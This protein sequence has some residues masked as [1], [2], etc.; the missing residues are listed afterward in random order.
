MA[1]IFPLLSSLPITNPVLIF[2]I[3]MLV[4]FLVPILSV[5]LRIP[6]IVGLIVTGIILGPNC[7]NVF[8]RDS[9]DSMIVVWGTVG[10]LYIMLIAGLEFDL[11]QFSRRKHRSIVFGLLEFVITMAATTYLSTLLL[12][13][14]LLS[15]ILL[16][17]M[18]A[19]R[20]LVAYPII[21]RLGLVKRDSI[22][23]TLGGTV[24]TDTATLLVLAVVA[25]VAREGLSVWFCCRL[26]ISLA[27]FFLI[28]FWGIPRLG[29][30]FFRNIGG[31]GGAQFLFVLTVVF[32]CGYLSY[33]AGI[34]PIIGAF[35]SG[36]AL[37]R[38]IPEDSLL[39]NRILFVG[40]N[41]FV[42]VFLFSIGM[43]VKVQNLLSDVQIWVV[44]GVM[45]ASA[46][47]TKYLA[48]RIVQWL[49]KYSTEESWVIFGL[50]I[51]QAAAALAIAE[52]GYEVGLFNEAVL[53]GTVILIIVTCLMSPWVVERFGRRIALEEEAPPHHAV[54]MN[55]RLLVPVSNP[56]TAD[57]I[58]DFALLF[59]DPLRTKAVYP[60]TVVPDDG[61]VCSH[62]ANG[63]KLVSSCLDRAVEASVTPVV[64]ADM[65]AVDGIT[66]AVKDLR[67]TTLIMGWGGEV[68]AGSLIFGNVLNQVL[69]RCDQR[70]I[71]CRLTHP[72]NTAK[73]LFLAL[74]PF[75]E[76]ESGFEETVGHFKRFAK[77]IG[78]NFSVILLEHNLSK[79][80]VH[81]ERAK[82]HIPA[83]FIS[84]PSW[85][86]VRRFI[87]SSLTQDDVVVILSARED[88]VSWQPGLDR[89]PEIV[90]ARLPQTNLVIVYPPIEPSDAAVASAPE[91]IS[92]SQTISAEE[93][94][95]LNLDVL[96]PEQAIEDIL[97]K[98]FADRPDD[99]G[100]LLAQIRETTGE[101]PTELL[102][103]V[104]LLHTHC[105]QVETTKVFFGVGR[106]GVNFAGAKHPAHIVFVVLSSLTQPP[107]VHL[108]TLVAIGRLFRTPGL[109]ERLSSAQSAQE[110]LDV[111]A[112]AEA[113][114]S[115]G[116]KKETAP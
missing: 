47:A 60:M 37:N 62:V 18:L 69:K 88:T 95:T 78:T 27:V 71:V 7:L 96:Q 114:Q 31:D 43:L 112:A 64:R 6:G 89:L 44:A 93:G 110:V 36:L 99:L 14:S 34:E 80:K 41:L 45:L 92:L 21:S 83:N 35:M 85:Q 59:R 76:H 87:V 116:V 63:E 5:R 67:A 49:F 102:P 73:R 56:A 103:G 107:E 54:T 55:E 98:T 58:V 2:A 30:W 74:P 10:L 109:S 101:H 108:R 13:F 52:V 20:T 8:S 72:L 79:I 4:I 82:P 81:V 68:S 39:R 15:A 91:T 111:I 17:S 40:N 84:K 28:V 33:A 26:T 23:T 32:G 51:A 24:I 66:R 57:A 113:E 50:S 29:R 90:A 106:A 1:Q 77:Q 38:L 42:P 19:S 70:V 105:A 22:T 53:D 61:E 11:Y 115:D 100:T 25:S 86:E 48:A 9:R 65:N 46:I 75:A 16:G 3:L 94:I 97:R 104:I 12:N